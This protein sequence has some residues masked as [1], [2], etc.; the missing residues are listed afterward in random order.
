MLDPDSVVR[1]SEF[2]TAANSAGV[3]ERIRA[4]W[5]RVSSGERLSQKTRLDFMSRSQ[6]LY[7]RQL[8]TQRRLDGRYSKLSRNFGVPS[9]LVVQDFALERGA[10]NILK[11]LIQRRSTKPI[12]KPKTIE[13]L[14]AM[15]PEQLETRKQELLRKR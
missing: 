2:A 1:E 7:D 13:Q 10:D 8:K 9:N 4:T 11:Q 15:T 3:P 14:R 12:A 6:K 5:N